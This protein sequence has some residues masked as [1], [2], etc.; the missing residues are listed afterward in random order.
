M[1]AS[2]LAR[3]DLIFGVEDQVQSYI[4]PVS[5]TGSAAG[6]DGPLGSIVS[7]TC[8]TPGAEPDAPTFDITTTPDATQRRALELIKQIRP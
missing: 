8:R 7:N 5:Q 4:R 3:D 6:A 2:R 1:D